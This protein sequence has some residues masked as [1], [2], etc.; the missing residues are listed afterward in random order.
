V[1]NTLR[2]QLIAIGLLVAL[3]ILVWWSQRPDTPEPEEAPEP[4]AT[5]SL[6]SDADEDGL[7][8]W[9]ERLWE[10][11]P[12]NRDSDGDTVNDGEEVSG[13]R[14]PS[15][16]GEGNKE[17]IA[18]IRQSSTV[19]IQPNPQPVAQPVT[20]TSQDLDANLTPEQRALKAYGNQLG[21]VL[22]AAA[23]RFQTL[24]TLFTTLI[25]NPSTETRDQVVNNGPTYT[26]LSASI[27]AVNAPTAA[28]S[29][30]SR[31]SANYQ[32]IASAIAAFR[33]EVATNI[34]SSAYN[35]YNSAAIES[36]KTLNAFADFFKERGIRFAP[37]EPGYIF[38]RP[39]Q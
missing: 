25:K 32:S 24:L 13:N 15:V 31:L 23:P 30:H 39:A 28:A 20:T 6:G 38:M 36:A 2:I 11:D 7:D 37:N 4:P 1:N 14:D 19:E 9:E 33:S 10:T 29:L 21:A 35:N 27:R 12:N 8:D 22:S 16:Y 17:R 26:E 3:I 5:V 18:I 34:S